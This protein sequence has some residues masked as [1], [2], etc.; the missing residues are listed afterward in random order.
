MIESQGN[1]WIE[2]L[3]SRK[4]VRPEIQDEQSS[5]REPKTSEAPTP[6]FLRVEKPAGPAP[7]GRERHPLVPHLCFGSPF[8]VRGTDAGS[9]SGRSPGGRAG[10]LGYL[11]LS[12]L[13]TKCAERCELVGSGTARGHELR[14]S[15]WLPRVYTGITFWMVTEASAE[16]CAHCCNGLMSHCIGL[17]DRASGTDCLHATPDRLALNHCSMFIPI[18]MHEYGTT[19]LMP[20][21]SCP[22]RLAWL[23]SRPQL[24]QK[25]LK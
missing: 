11:R 5:A 20:E 13:S 6:E 7:A 12:R 16:K 8:S 24:I 15:V 18:F 14:G 25:A 3:S 19:A 4:T 17:A 22:A 10:K 9:G 23:A 2:A 21:F 1:G